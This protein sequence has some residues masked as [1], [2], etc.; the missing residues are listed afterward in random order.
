MHV[1]YGWRVISASGKCNALKYQRV[2]TSGV[3]WDVI[4][5]SHKVTFSIPGL[6]GAMAV[7]PSLGRS[8]LLGDNLWA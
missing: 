2:R 8:A 5:K 4:R 7:C 3:A 1:V 6:G